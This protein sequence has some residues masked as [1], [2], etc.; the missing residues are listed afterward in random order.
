MAKIKSLIETSV[1]KVQ[2]VTFASNEM[3]KLSSSTD[4]VVLESVDKVNVLSNEM[5]KI[6]LNI[7]KV[8]E[9]IKDVSGKN[10]QIVGIISNI[11]EI[12]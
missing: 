10:S 3:N 2:N 11:N 7:R 6:T 8:V 1:Q 4:T 12:T 5:D 9:Q